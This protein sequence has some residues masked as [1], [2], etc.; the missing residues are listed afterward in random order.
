ML[1]PFEGIQVSTVSL[2]GG[3]GVDLPKPIT[4][5]GRRMLLPFEGIQVSTVSLGGGVGC[6]FAQTYHR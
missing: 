6:W 4:A 3:Q 1:I 5:N 2:G